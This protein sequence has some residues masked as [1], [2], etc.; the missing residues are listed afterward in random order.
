[1]GTFIKFIAVVGGIGPTLI[2]ADAY[3]R[4]GPPPLD[5]AVMAFLISVIGLVAGALIW[6]T[7]D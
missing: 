2:F 1:M 5:V 3:Y 7:T 4:L 6:Q